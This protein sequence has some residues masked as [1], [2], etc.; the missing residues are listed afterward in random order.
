[1]QRYC[2][3]L[4]LVDDPG[5][6]REYEQHHNNVWPEVEKSIRQSGILNMSIYRISNRL[7]MIIEVQ[8]DF[9]FEKKEAMDQKNP[10]VQK[11]EAL[12]CGYQQEI[13]GSPPGIKWR[14]MKL[15]YDLNS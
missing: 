8:D 10:T 1:M 11:W 12:M 9:S 14:L 3:T 15:I 5:L 13:P 6:I 7:F 4:D 2:L